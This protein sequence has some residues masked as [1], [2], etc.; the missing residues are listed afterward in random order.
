MSLLFIFSTISAFLSFFDI[1]FTLI[2]HSNPI[3]I[4]LNPGEEL[5]ESL[6]LI[7]FCL[8]LCLSLCLSN[9]DRLLQ[10]HQDSAASERDTSLRV[11]DLCLQS[12]LRIH[13]KCVCMFVCV[14]IL[15]VCMLGGGRLNI[16]CWMLPLSV[17]VPC[18]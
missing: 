9:S 13:C 2:L 4:C 12:Y 8:S 10:L 1:I 11:W 5:L 16:C 14:N 7:I 3:H 15:C 17:C 18:G 6:C